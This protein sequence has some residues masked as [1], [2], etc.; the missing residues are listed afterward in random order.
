MKRNTS[1]SGFSL[2]EMLVYISVLSMIF[3]V[4]VATIVSFT[5]SY[6]TLTAHRV[7]EHS[8][9][10]SFERLTRDIRGATS[11]DMGNSTFASNPG[12]LTLIT[13]HKAVSTTTKFYIE[14]G[15]LKLDVNGSYVGPLTT[16][17]VTVTNMTYTLLSGSTTQ[18]VRIQM[19]VQGSSG[20]VTQEK[21]YQSTIVL[22]GS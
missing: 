14:N 18:A 8:A 20:S 9:L 5:S 3:I 1:Q 2:I 17:K 15:I 13:T 10:S 4:V 21:N 22:K 7:I 11:I 6:R 19:T 16:S 12:R